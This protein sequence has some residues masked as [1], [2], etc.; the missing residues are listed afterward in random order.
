MIQTYTELFDV[1]LHI[2]LSV[3][4][5]PFSKCDSQLSDCLTAVQLDDDFPVKFDYYLWPEH[6]FQ[7]VVAFLL[8][9]KDYV[10]LEN[11]FWIYIFI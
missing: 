1:Q 2:L 10:Y 4:P 7:P 3:V 9:S 11:F 5:L 6:T 8:I